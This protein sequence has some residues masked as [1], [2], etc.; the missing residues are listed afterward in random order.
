MSFSDTRCWN[1]FWISFG[2]NMVDW[3]AKIFPAPCFRKEFETAAPG[4]YRLYISGLGFYEAYINGHRVGDG[5]FAPAPTN[6]D[7]HTGYLVHDVSGYLKTG[8]NTIAVML[9]NGPYNCHTADAWHL[10]KATWRDYPKLI[11]EITCGGK[12]IVASDDTWRV[13]TSGPV[14]F[15]GFRNGEFYDARLEMTG[16]TDN[17]FDDSGWKQA[18]IVPGPGGILFEQTAPPCRIK[19]LFAMREIQPGLWDSGQN[20]AGRA[21][22]TV[23][24][25]PGST[26][27]LQYG[28]VLN[29]DGSLH[30]DDIGRFCFSGEFQTEKYTLKGD[31]TEVWHSRFTYHGFRY[32]TAE[33]TGEAKIISLTAQAIHSDLTEIGGFTSSHPD[34]NALEHCTYWSFVNNFVGIPT[35]CPHREKNGWVNDT[36]LASDTGLFHF[37]L[38]GGYREWLGSLR[39]SQRPSGQCP[40]MTPTSGWGYNWGSGPLFDTALMS[41]PRRIYMYRGDSS[42][43]RENYEAF[44]LNMEFA[45]GMAKDNIYKSGLG[46]WMHYRPERAVPPE[47]VNTGWYYYDLSILA[48]A[49]ELFNFRDDALRYREK[50][51][52]VAEAFNAR[53]ANGNGSFANDEKTALAVAAG[54]GLCSGN[55]A[56]LA[57]ARLEQQVRNDAY[58][59]DF[60]IVGAKL[61]PRVLAEFGYAETG[62]NIFTQDKYP[63][64]C[65]WVRDGETTLLEDFAGT[66]S[67][68]HI[69]YGDISAWM[70]QYAGGL[71]PDFSRPGF[72]EVVLKFR[73]ILSLSSMH[74]WYDSIYGRIETEWKRSAGGVHFTARIPDGIPGKVE[75][76]DGSEIAFCNS[77]NTVW[78]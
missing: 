27:K 64:W 43:M 45:A 52:L 12:S 55:E 42:A 28:D 77:I 25:K 16:W 61:V 13:T 75:F 41:I 15:D 6:Y 44:K 54:F 66:S 72:R 51:R 37:D 73:N 74:T 70:M 21:E 26:V 78:K 24:G 14:T 29:P 58:I 23:Q 40:G 30:L 22:I 76:P 65:K 56:K 46:D 53:F 32:V 34:I 39:D 36:Q 7:R 31:D 19:K 3:R 69:M 38:T 47:L 33:I 35:D 68:N 18:E 4:E 71:E 57:A 62:F 5:E 1:A 49:A 8:K 63:G 9:G 2:E 17:G 67:H 10:D 20:I 59:A 60:G 50:A 11:A 48:D